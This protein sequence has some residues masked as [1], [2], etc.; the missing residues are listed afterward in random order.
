MSNVYKLIKKYINILLPVSIWSVFF[1][2]G[3]IQEFYKKYPTNK[4]YF[5]VL[6]DYLIVF[7]TNWDADYY[8]KIAKI[9]YSLKEIKLFAFFPTFPHQIRLFSLLF[10][11]INVGAV[12]ASLFNFV[13]L[14]FIYIKIIEKINLSFGLGINKYLLYLV[15]IFLPSNIFLFLPYTEGLYLIF[16][17]LSIYFIFFVNSKLQL[18]LP[19]F[20]TSLVMTRSLGIFFAITIFLIFGISLVY[21]KGII[22]N[23]LNKKL[24]ILSC[25]PAIMS[26][27]LFQYFGQLITGDFWVSRNV[28]TLW[29][30]SSVSIWNIFPTVIDFTSKTAISCYNKSGCLP[31]HIYELISFYVIFTLIILTALYLIKNQ[32]QSNSFF[33]FI[34][35][36]TSIPALYLPITTGTLY[37]LNRIIIVAPIYIFLIP[38]LICKICKNRYI[39]AVLISMFIAN[40]LLGYYLFLSASWIG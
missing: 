26:Q 36:I 20:L 10:E 39:L 1:I 12:L 3:F 19:I 4:N 2:F 5:Q 13:V 25:A 40:G 7:S 28:Q 14:S 32:N 17:L 33:V 38:I 24:I 8:T 31:W 9:G 21:N 37:S 11:N 15:Y 22:K 29:G 23:Q 34:I 35:L 16:L 18:L 27:L 30:R 6:N